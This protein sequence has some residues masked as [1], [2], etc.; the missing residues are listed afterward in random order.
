[1]NQLVKDQR[2][3]RAHICDLIFNAAEER[4]ETWR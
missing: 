3:P 2:G 1:M 4:Q